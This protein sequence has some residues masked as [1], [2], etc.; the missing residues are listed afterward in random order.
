MSEP[1]IRE[2]SDRFLQAVGAL[3]LNWAVIETALDFCCAIVFHEFDGR[4]I[5]PEIPRSLGVKLKFLKRGLKDPRLAEVAAYGTDLIQELQ[6]LKDSRH[7]VVHGA[8]S[9]NAKED[10]VVMLRVRY[11]KHA[12]RTSMHTVTADEVIAASNKALSFADPTIMLGV[13]LFNIARPDDKMDNP[14]G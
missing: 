5:E 4:K 9:G 13:A 14:F 11:E 2:P 6:N 7:E 8:L 10:T 1:T 3:T 12:H